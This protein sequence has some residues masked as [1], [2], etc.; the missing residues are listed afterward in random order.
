[1]APMAIKISDMLNNLEEDYKTAITFIEYLS[2]TRKQKRANED[3]K[4]LSEIQDIFADDKGW[5]SKED[6]LPCH[7]TGLS[8]IQ[9]PLI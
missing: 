7:V 2:E 9:T 6:I 1:M 4:I 5:D 3:K 8:G